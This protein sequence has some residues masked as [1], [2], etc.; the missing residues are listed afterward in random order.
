MLRRP[1]VPNLQ[2]R[3]GGQHSEVYY[4]VVEPKSERGFLG[5][6]RD[7]TDPLQDREDLPQHPFFVDEEG[8]DTHGGEDLAYEKNGVVVIPRTERHRDVDDD[9]PE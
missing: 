9:I 7:V 3:D 2:V 4:P 8:S 1:I 5:R 6:P